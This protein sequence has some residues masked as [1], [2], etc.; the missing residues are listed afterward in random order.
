MNNKSK[1]VQFFDQAYICKVN[2]QISKY[3]SL[4]TYK[5]NIERNKPIVYC[6]EIDIDLLHKVN[7]R[8]TRED[9]LDSIEEI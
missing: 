9:L 6:I 4:N 2:T 5:I 7:D 1:H 8:E 3:D